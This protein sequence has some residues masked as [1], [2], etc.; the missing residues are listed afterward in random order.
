MKTFYVNLVKMNYMLY[1]LPETREGRCATVE[2]PDRKPP[3]LCPCGED[4]RLGTHS[5]LNDIF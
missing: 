2:G 4:E 5:A 3:V 1:V